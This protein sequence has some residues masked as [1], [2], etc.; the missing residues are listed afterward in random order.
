MILQ[1]LKTGLKKIRFINEEE[2]N[3]EMSLD[4]Y[5]IKKR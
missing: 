5:I 2:E 1:L 4:T 3:N